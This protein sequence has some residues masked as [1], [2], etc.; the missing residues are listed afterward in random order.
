MAGGPTTVELVAAAADAG[1]FG[2]LAAGY[3]SVDSLSQRIDDLRSR[4]PHPF[5]VNLFVPAP[6]RPELG[7]AAR[8]YGTRLEP[9]A[10]LSGIA[11]GQPRWDDDHYDA[12][13]DLL[14]DARP[15]VVSF[16]FGWPSL[17]DVD[18]LRTAGVEVWVTVNDP[19][20]VEWAL[21]L[22]VDA[23]VAQGDEAGGHR[24]GPVDEPHG[25]P[26]M[27][28]VAA[29]RTL[30]GTRARVVAAGGVMTALD[31]AATLAVGAD[32][33]ACGT[34]F[35]RAD[36]AGTAPVHRDALAQDTG[37]V[38]T[39]A[40]TGR[41]A[42]AL[43]SSWTDLFTLTAPAAYPHVH[44]LTKPLRDHGRTTGAPDLVHLWAGTGHAS[45]RAVPAADIARDLLSGAA[46]VR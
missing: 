31:V 1:C 26:R 9:L 19:R 7:Q 18:R 45:A 20:Q 15:S 27:D 41:S 46:D 12:K 17:N 22:G 28:L 40:F 36:E 11:L 35:L 39:R 8:D 10:E 16:A 32:A 6:D 4:S 13:V 14:V 37:T 43:R 21:E 38:V 25:I 30:V 34:A 29:V 5:G 23:V 24:G 33:V 44:H 42:R 3:L 2:F